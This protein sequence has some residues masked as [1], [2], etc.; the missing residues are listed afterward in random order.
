MYAIRLE[1]GREL[2]DLLFQKMQAKRDEEELAAEKYRA[3]R[4]WYLRRIAGFSLHLGF[5]VGILIFV[6]ADISK[7]SELKEKRAELAK[8]PNFYAAHPILDITKVEEVRQKEE[9][10]RQLVGQRLNVQSGRLCLIPTDSGERLCYE[11]RGEFGGHTY[12]SYINALNGKQEE[13]LKVVESDTG[14][15]AV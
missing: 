1:L 13:L 11:F 2:E 15:E 3:K 14:L 6:F 7:Y 8:R 10:A 12:L 5:L 4:A 9:E